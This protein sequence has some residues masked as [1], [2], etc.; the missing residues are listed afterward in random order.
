MECEAYDGGVHGTRCF[1]T[2][3]RRTNRTKPI[4]PAVT[5]PAMESPSER[6][7]HECQIRYPNPL[8]D[9]RNSTATTPNNPSPS[10]RRKLLRM[11]GSAAG[12]TTLKYRSR[13]LTL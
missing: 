5:R 13:V 2:R 12:K 6:I 9:I 8:L 3:S 4:R 11:I 7:C 10:D 1:S